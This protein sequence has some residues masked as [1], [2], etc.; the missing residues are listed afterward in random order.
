L[1][2]GLSP[3]FEARR[4]DCPICGGGQLKGLLRAPDRFQGKP[5]R[6]ELDRCVSC[7]LVFQNPRLTDRGLEYYYGDFYDGIGAPASEQYY[8]LG[9]QVKRRQA[10]RV[11]G[12]TVPHRWL[13]VGGGNGSFCKVAAG[14][15]PATSFEVVDNSSLV[16]DAL[17]NG[18]ATEVHQGS[19]VDLAPSLEGRYD[20]V[21]MHHYLEHTID[22]EAEIEAARRVLAPGGVL[23][24][25]VP[26][27]ESR[28]GLLV[29]SY[30]W[31]WL[32]PQHLNL[33]PASTLTA[34]VERHGFTSAVLD[35]GGAHVPVD[36]LSSILLVA[37]GL[38]PTQVA[39]WTAERARW[40]G[41]ARGLIM[42]VFVPVFLVAFV[43]DQLWAPVARRG[44]RLTNMYAL[45]AR[46][47]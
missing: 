47:G 3:F 14:V 20:V 29:K 21:T 2:G 39:P 34:L 12:L 27:P 10:Q 8:Q 32:Q 13:D 23:V 18:W 19:L 16:H 11:E 24:I 25:E 37:L 30:W 41:L 35:R 43:A 42:A 15:W 45:I 28:Y 36:L 44:H 26:D 6:F 38:A 46:R 31:Q 7:G 1:A 40:R 5:G 33:F 9:E 22:P 17:S 4:D